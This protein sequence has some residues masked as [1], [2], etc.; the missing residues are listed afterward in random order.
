MEIFLPPEATVLAGA[1]LP[2]GP[3]VM[4]VRPSSGASDQ[5]TQPGVERF[6]LVVANAKREL[7]IQVVSGSPGQV[8]LRLLRTGHGLLRIGHV[9][10]VLKA[11][12]SEVHVV[13]TVVTELETHVVPC[14]GGFFMLDSVGVRLWT[15]SSGW[16]TS[17]DL[18]CASLESGDVVV[19]PLDAG[20]SV[21][22]IER[23]TRRLLR[24]TQFEI[25]PD[26]IGIGRSGTREIELPVDAS[27]L[28]EVR[29]RATGSRTI[30]ISD[31]LSLVSL[32]PEGEVEGIHE[33]VKERPNGM[34]PSTFVDRAWESSVSGQV[35]VNDGGGGWPMNLRAVRMGGRASS[36]EHNLESRRR[37]LDADWVSASACVSLQ[38]GERADVAVYHSE[39]ANELQK[40]AELHQWQQT[41]H[42]QVPTLRTAFPRVIREADL[43]F[44]LL[45]LR[46][47]AVWSG[48]L[49]ALR[50]DGR[51][52][53]LGADSD[54]WATSRGPCLDGTQVLVSRNAEWV[55][56]VGAGL[57]AARIGRSIV[58]GRNIEV[59]ESIDSVA[60]TDGG[61]VYVLSDNQV[62]AYD[63]RTARRI[64]ALPLD[65]SPDDQ[66]GILGVK[67]EDLVFVT[68]ETDNE[69][70]N[71][72][73][74][75]S[76]D[77]RIRIKRQRWNPASIA[78]DTIGSTRWVLRDDDDIDVDM[79]KQSVLLRRRERAWFW[80]VSSAQSIWD[81]YGA[82]TR[83]H[84]INFESPEVEYGAADSGVFA[85]VGKVLCRAAEVLDEGWEEVA[86]QVDDWWVSA[87]GD[88]V[89]VRR[90]EKVSLLWFGSSEASRP[91]LSAWQR[92]SESGQQFKWPELVIDPNA[93][94]YGREQGREE[95]IFSLAG[96]HVG[97]TA[98]LP[99]AERRYR[100]RRLLLEP[101]PSHYALV[102]EKKELATW[103]EPG[104]AQ[105]LKRLAYRIA[106]F[107]KQFASRGQGVEQALSQ[108]SDDLAYLKTEFYDGL[109]DFDWPSAR[110]G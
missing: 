35:L 54:D 22:V 99:E 14:A 100:L 82:T 48:A 43:P 108:W 91:D 83:W 106:G 32:S 110:R 88:T 96:Y 34:R 104:T 78:P 33:A 42:F 52:W 40:A 5:L 75:Y 107:W 25:G 3:V 8:D 73:N 95:G 37:L 12:D 21:R 62:L 105:R 23:L 87:S 94:S 19:E 36:A 55:L 18:V 9:V 51:L 16:S 57:R 65:K 76:F 15:A 101:L 71:P 86:N 92:A 7:Q 20:E 4:L 26:G 74:D 103:G 97:E 109:H 80:S 98:G 102:I 27:R 63:A 17:E 64:G 70:P 85:L 66:A 38:A 31:R 39:V 13:A 79:G 81:P 89:C 84:T 29:K 77:T 28:V 2:D 58:L 50:N 49:V 10:H 68:A 46:D 45:E 47:I 56:A 1:F 61:I 90:G 44:P 11:A 24:I 53:A 60:I 30:W 6:D 41:H 67:G 93:R 69:T 59:S 72:R